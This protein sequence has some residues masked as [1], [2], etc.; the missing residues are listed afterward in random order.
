MGTRR[1]PGIAHV[2]L[3]S[4]GVLFV[5]RDLPAQTPDRA[6]PCLR[7]A[8]GPW[9]PPLDWAEAGHAGSAQGS[10][11]AARR[12]R[13]S[14]FLQQPGRDHGDGMAWD[15]RSNGTRLYLFPEW[16][17]AGV[18]I[19]FDSTSLAGDT[20]R[21]VAQAMVA[22]GDARRSTTRVRALRVACGKSR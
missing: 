2:L 1:R 16:W 10:G 12:L 6:P 19:Q 20:L 11:E 22:D 9:Q 8:F 4:M 5:A 15:E 18:V 14:I 3:A 21:G 7:F 17:P 13:D